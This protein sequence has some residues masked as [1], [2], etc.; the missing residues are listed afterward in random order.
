MTIEKIKDMIEGEQYGFLRTNP[1]LKGQL[2]F[3]TLGGSYAYGTNVETSDVDIR[4][5]ALNSSKDLIGLSNFEQVVDTRTDTTIYSFNKLINLLLNCN[6]NTIEL[7][8]CK[9]EHYF[10]ITEPGM[11]LIS[12]KRLFLSQR[13]ADSFGGY[14]TQQLRRL[15]NALAR[16]R[17]PQAQVEEHIKGALE[18]AIKSFGDRYAS[19]GNGGI[20]LL[21]AESE[22]DNL[23][24]EVFCNI[25]LDKYP[26]REFQTLLNT[27]SS[28]VS[29]YEKLNHRNHKKDDNH[30]NKHAM[31][32]IRLY[33]MC[34]DILENEEIRTYRDADK[35]FLLSIRNGVFQNEDGSY[36]PEFFELVSGFEKRLQYDKKNTSLPTTPN[37]KRVEDFVM[38][39]NRRVVCD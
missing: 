24:T 19:F 6:P 12:N 26:A 27:L 11:Q 23:D 38:T 10:M 8:G 39:I 22:R 17:L 5:C 7:L 21:T 20:E 31:H 37:M 28:V 18:R 30:L 25:H 2:M 33:L 3:L 32:L 14:A 36:R 34:F 35:D 1:H 9:P 29:N 13:A 15:Q 4:G 16:D